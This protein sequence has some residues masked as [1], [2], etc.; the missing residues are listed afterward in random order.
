M[1]YSYH[2]RRFAGVYNSA[3]WKSLRARKLHA[4]M[5]ECERCQRAIAGRDAEIHHDR[6]LAEG[7]EP[8]PALDGLTALCRE[9]HADVHRELNEEPPERRAWRLHLREVEESL[10]R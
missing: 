1:A 4:V 7:G 9:C 3:A 10:N 5:F 8:Y 2:G 6:P